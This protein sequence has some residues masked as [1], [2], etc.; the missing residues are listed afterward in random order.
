MVNNFCMSE[1]L[2][3]I[4]YLLFMSS[5]SVVVLFI[6]ARLLGKR[7]ISQLDFMDYIIGISIGSISAEMATDISDKPWAYY[8]IAI[9]IYFLFD[10]LINW[11]GRKTP[12]LKQFLKGKPIVIV[13][14]GKIDY[15]NLKKSKLSVN[16][17]ISLSREQGYFDLTDIYY[18]ILE[19]SGKLSIMPIATEKPT[20][21]GDFKDTKIDIP[22]LPNYIVVDGRISYSTLRELNKEKDWLMKKLK[23]N[24]SKD[25]KKIILAIYDAKN[26]KMEISFKE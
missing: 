4:L 7:Q 22:K 2:K 18:A 3:E 12:K 6:I 8:I 11:L 19:D 20:V 26:D 17:V 21:V 10:L 5:T 25:L 14:E 15:K 13:Y 9:V 24:N 1:T 16:D 23:A